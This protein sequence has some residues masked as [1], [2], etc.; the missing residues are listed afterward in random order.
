MSMDQSEGMALVLLPDQKGIPGNTVRRQPPYG[1][2][3]IC[4]VLVPCDEMSERGAHLPPAVR[5]YLE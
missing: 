2:S 4:L 3:L 1:S 5:R